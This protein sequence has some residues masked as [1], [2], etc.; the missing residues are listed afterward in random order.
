MDVLRPDHQ[1]ANQLRVLWHFRTDRILHGAY[2][3]DAVHERAHTADALRERPC[4][5]GIAVPQD[6]LDASHHGAGRIRLGDLVAVHLRFDSQ[7]AFDTSDRIDN[8]SC[9][10]ASS[11]RFSA[12]IS[13]RL[14]IL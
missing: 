3:G 14:P 13:M 4:V 5:P 1:V 10:H 8:D 12:T 7:V 2:R 9:V 6:D 11:S